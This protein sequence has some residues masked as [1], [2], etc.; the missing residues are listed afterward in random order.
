MSFEIAQCRNVYV[1][2]HNGHKERNYLFYIITKFQPCSL[3]G[4]TGPTV[5]SFCADN[6]VHNI[7]N[8]P[9][10]YRS[11]DW[12]LRNIHLFAAAWI[13]NTF[14]ATKT[15]RSA[16]VLVLHYLFGGLNKSFYLKKTFLIIIIFIQFRIYKVTVF[17]LIAPER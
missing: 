3:P 5:E 14:R 1:K 17:R 15:G 2:M 7:Y 10:L 11:I 16:S 8:D 13:V 4:T 12:L 9:N 6:N